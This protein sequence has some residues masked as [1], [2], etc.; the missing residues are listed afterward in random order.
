MK[1]LIAAA[2]FAAN[3]SGLQRHAFNMARCLLGAPEIEA[4]HF[5]VAPWQ[6]EMI[7]ASRLQ[8]DA[9]F[10]LHVAEM[11]RTS[12]GR[13][14]WYYRKLPGL[15]RALRADL[16]HLTYPMPVNASA[17]RCP[18]IVTL[19][20]LYPFEIPMN[21]GFPK[22]IFN[23]LAL[24]QCLGS[25]DAIACVSE[26]TKN[27]L[28]AF[29]PAYSQKAIRIFN[30]VEPGRSYSAVSPL[31]AWADDP[32]LLCVAQHRKNKNLDILIRSYR[33]LL[34]S[35]RIPA[36]MRLLIVG[37]SGP[38]TNRIRRLISDSALGEHVQLREGFS[39]PELQWCYRQCEALVSPSLT[40]GFGL[41]VAEALLAGCR[42][43]CSEIPAHWEIGA[44]RC[45]FVN[46]QQ[47]EEH[48][49]MQ[50]L[51]AWLKGSLEPST[52]WNFR[53]PLWRVSTLRFTA[54]CCHVAQRLR[55]YERSRLQLRR[56]RRH[57]CI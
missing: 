28:Q 36:V 14:L 54:G 46:L 22:F 10:I 29:L 39:E 17:F 26:A 47:N 3:I 34:K 24:R 5:V 55:G 49:Q 23:R 9:R 16:V 53:R 11:D 38:E 45:R 1:I 40:E 8:L 31:D 19:H 35:G 6:Q 15:A 25:V 2:S 43:V 20:D 27:K 18:I 56:D 44:G 48:N 42:V 7:G 33:R 41:P 12:V 13:N 51:R 52:F 32:F 4:V 30:C 50:S 37:I 57:E 21:F